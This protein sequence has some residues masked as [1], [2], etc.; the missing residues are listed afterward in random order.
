MIEQSDPTKKHLTDVALWGVS[1]ILVTKFY[2]RTWAHDGRSNLQDQIIGLLT[3]K[4]DRL[5]ELNNGRFAMFATSGILAAEL[6]TGQVRIWGWNGGRVSNLDSLTWSAG[7]LEGSLDDLGYPGNP[8]FCIL[9]CGNREPVF[10]KS[11]KMP[12]PPPNLM[13][14]VYIYERRFGFVAL[15]LPR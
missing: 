13:V 11:W 1:Q 8:G 5:Q 12:P 2:V 10:P 3:L 7:W 4:T 6:Y 15:A 9:P 14:F